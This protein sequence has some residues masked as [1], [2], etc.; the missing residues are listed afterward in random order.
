[1]TSSTEVGAKGARHGV[2]TTMGRR[3]GRRSILLGAASAVGTALVGRPA[4][5]ATRGGATVLLYH[6]IG[7][8][9]SE[10]VISAAAL[11]AQLDALERAGASIV[12]LSQVV[13]AVEGKGTLPPRAVALTFDDGFRD[14][15]LIASRLLSARRMPFT[16]VLSTDPIERKLRDVV[17]WDQVRRCVD[18]GFAE[19]ASHGHVHGFMA[20]MDAATVWREVSMSREIVEARL[21]VVPQTFHY[22]FGSTSPTAEMLAARAGYRAA[23][24]AF[25]DDDASADAPRFR[26]PRF[27]VSASLRPAALVARV[28]RRW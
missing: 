14:A 27:G 16:L 12:A 9:D 18:G 15:A 2:V 5:A 8:D 4:H 23:F 3:A 6:A 7:E 26:L 1:M 22:P 19:V 21:G 17:S 11:E 13:D 28:S 24:T 25:G 20:R 10:L